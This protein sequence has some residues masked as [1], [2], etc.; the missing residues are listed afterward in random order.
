MPWTRMLIRLYQKKKKGYNLRNHLCYTQSH[1]YWMQTAAVTRHMPHVTQVPGYHE[2]SYKVVIVWWSLCVDQCVVTNVWWSFCVD[3][4]VLIIVC[5]SLCVDCCVLI[6]VCWSLC[7]DHCVLIIVCWSMCGD[8]CVM[9][10]VCWSLWVDHCVLIIVCWST[11]YPRK[12][13]LWQN[14]QM[15]T[16]LTSDWEAGLFRKGSVRT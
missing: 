11:S 10:I 2:C 7:V 8:Q 4:C 12:K 13:A 16:Q 3:H 5:W 1:I 6:I 14:D 9:I 15:V